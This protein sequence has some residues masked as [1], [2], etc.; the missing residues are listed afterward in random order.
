MIALGSISPRSM[1]SKQRLEILVRVGLAHL[2]REPFAERRADR[3]R[4]DEAGVDAGE[5]NGRAF[6]GR[7]NSLAQHVR[8]VL[9]ELRDLL[10]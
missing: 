7:L 6:A 8:A 4:I 10:H 1:R 9:L 5:R 2:E 3:N